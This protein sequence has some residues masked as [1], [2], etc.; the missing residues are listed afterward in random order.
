MSDESS[1][2]PE[3]FAVRPKIGAHLAGCGLRDFYLR[4][5]SGR[6]ETF[7]DGTNRMVTVRSIRADQQQMLAT[8][9]GSPRDNPSRRF[10]GPGRPKSKR[11]KAAATSS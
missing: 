9:H 2:I 6:Y 3:P 8:N 11:K 5:N 10:G 7:L 4:L 1:I